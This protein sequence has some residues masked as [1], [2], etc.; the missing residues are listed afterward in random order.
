MR[1]LLITVVLTL[2]ASVAAA[3][4]ALAHSGV[5]TATPG[6][7]DKVQAGVD[8]LEMTFR[9]TLDPSKPV[10]V[11]LLDSHNNNKIDGEAR[12]AG[13]KVTARLQPLEAGLHKVR[14]SV[15]FPD[16]HPTTGSYY[17]SVVPKPD[18]AAAADMMPYLIGGAAALVVAGVVVVL[19]LRRRR[20]MP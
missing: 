5:D 14:Y 19:I 7:G 15:V 3:G 9:G 18:D 17:F 6:P 20:R 12:A 1:K 2:L 13:D 4:T 8:H 16:G 11:E 10:R